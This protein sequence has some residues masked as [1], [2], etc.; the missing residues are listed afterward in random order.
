MI[1]TRAQQKVFDLSTLFNWF[2]IYSY[3]GWL[4]ESL[5]C[6][7]E[8]GRYVSRG[9]LYGPFCPI[10][11]SCIVFM[12]LL[13]TDRCKSK[14]TLFLSCALFASVLEYVVSFSM[15]HIFGRR[16]WDYSNRLLNING[17]ICIGAAFVFGVSGVLVI[18]YL[19]PNLVRYMNSNFNVHT[20]RNAAKLLLA[21]FLL[22]LLA[23]IQISFT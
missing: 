10:Y 16:W 3:I 9:F 21:V 20:L 19:H 22:D 12:I 23:S 6:S 2:I 1:I 14:L 11:G 5:Y 17:R 8:A 4:Y 15:E 13:F 7:I 18:R